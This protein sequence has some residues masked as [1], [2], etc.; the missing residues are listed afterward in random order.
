MRARKL[1]AEGHPLIIGPE[2]LQKIGGAVE[3]GLPALLNARL[4][5]LPTGGVEVSD[6]EAAEAIARLRQAVEQALPEFERDHL[7]ST[8]GL[9]WNVF[10]G[11]V[12]A[13]WLPQRQSIGFL[14][15]LVD[16]AA[17]NGVTLA[18]HWNRERV[19]PPLPLPDSLTPLIVG[20]AVGA[21]SGW[22]FTHNHFGDQVTPLILMGT[23]L[24]G[25][26]V[27]QRVFKRARCGD[28]LCRAPVGL[29]ASDCT[30]CGARLS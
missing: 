28:G 18:L 6:D 24:V 25:G 16:R 7:G 21:V 1:N 4:R 2:D 12:V 20:V 23:G 17:V 8:S 29:G 22:V 10:F 5:V 15:A 11:H 9:G 27:W 19:V 30:S 13:F 3:S 26:R 14:R